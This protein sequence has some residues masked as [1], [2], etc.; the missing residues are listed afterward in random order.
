[1]S[2]LKKIGIILILFGIGLPLILLAFATPLYVPQRGLIR[3]IQTMEIVI[4]ESKVIDI[5]QLRAAGFT[6]KEIRE[7]K[8]DLK[9]GDI[10]T[11]FKPLREYKDD[12]KAEPQ[13]DFKV[14]EGGLKK[15]IFDTLDPLS[16]TIEKEKIAIPYRY[17]FATGI[18]LV[19]TGIGV[20]VL[21]N[22][23]RSGV[24]Q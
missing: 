16:K 10:I 12:L 24:N 8:D 6:D 3:N 18:I 7:A 13:K 4:R 2:K 17:V 1:M 11:G 22:N 19:F 23:R 9:E 20:I 14:L 21:S 5:G 15:D